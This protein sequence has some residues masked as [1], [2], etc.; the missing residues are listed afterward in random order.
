MENQDVQKDVQD[1]SETDMP[2]GGK[3]LRDAR[4]SR[5]LSV[6]EVASQLHLTAQQIAA[7][8]AED[9]SRLPEPTY[10]C[11]YV[12]NYARFLGLSSD[13]VIKCYPNLDGILSS[14]PAAVA[15]R[16]TREDIEK[17]SAGVP[18]SVAVGF[19][20]LVL[21]ASVWFFISGDESEPLDLTGMEAGDTS[22]EPLVQKSTDA[23]TTPSSTAMVT[24]DLDAE[25]PPDQNRMQEI[26]EA[27]VSPTPEPPVLVRPEPPAPV[28]AEPEPSVT[29]DSGPV[30]ADSQAPVAREQSAAATSPPGLIAASKLVIR[31]S[32]DSWTDVTDAQGKQVLYRLGRAGTT[33]KVIGVAPFN[34]FFGYVPGVEIEINGRAMDMSRYQLLEKATVKVGTADSNSLTYGFYPDQQP[35]PVTE[36]FALLPASGRGSGEEKEQEAAVSAVPATSDMQPRKTDE[37]E[38]TG[39]QMQ[40][41]PPARE[42]R[43]RPAPITNLFEDDR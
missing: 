19:V 12:R 29:T 17:S 27:T 41:K 3:Q 23:G 14:K 32:L 5:G 7:L 35:T 11:G 30:V 33:V 9:F 43:S 24:N 38:D 2:S 13:Q 40:S 25:T 15:G 37:S 16:I 34:A 42:G 21:V 28:S 22:A 18:V 31:F 6:D 36:K 8:E 39:A 10:V 26:A 20:L 4:E 1:S